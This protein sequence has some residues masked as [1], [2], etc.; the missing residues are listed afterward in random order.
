VELGPSRHL[1]FILNFSKKTNP[2]VYLNTSIKFYNDV[3]ADLIESD[4]V[5]I[6][7]KSNPEFLKDW[8]NVIELMYLGEDQDTSR[9]PLD[10]S[11]YTPKQAKVI[12][13]VHR[14]LSVDEF[15]SYSDV[16]E[17]AGFPNAQRFVGTT[18]KICRQYPIIPC[19]RVKNSQWIKRFKKQDQSSRKIRTPRT[20]L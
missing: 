7:E 2:E 3:K 1:G 14:K 6:I 9:I 8:A 20:P 5:S 17:I 11:D 16:A 18:M 13:T 4:K 12:D 10:L 15:Y 19:K